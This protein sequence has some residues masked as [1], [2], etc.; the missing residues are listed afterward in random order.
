MDHQRQKHISS[1]LN[2]NV[3]DADLH[4][5]LVVSAIKVYPLDVDL[6]GFFGEGNVLL[7]ANLWGQYP[8]RLFS[9]RVVRVDLASR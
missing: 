5:E 3:L 2:A 7:H 1:P 6:A 8:A 4:Q 9:F